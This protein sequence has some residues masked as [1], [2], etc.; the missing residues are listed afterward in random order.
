[1]RL[2][3]N[4]KHVLA[5]IDLLADQCL[6]WKPLV[7]AEAHN[8]LPVVERLGGEQKERSGGIGVRLVVLV[9]QLF[10]SDEVV[11]GGNEARVADASRGA[12]IA[13]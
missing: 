2:A 10:L 6:L 5:L 12:A 4:A 9:E 13:G 8:G 1:M 11:V 3:V 7:A